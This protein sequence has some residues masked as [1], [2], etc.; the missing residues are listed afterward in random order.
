MNVKSKGPTKLLNIT[1]NQTFYEIELQYT[2]EFILAQISSLKSL[3]LDLESIEHIAT[4]SIEDKLTECIGCIQ[5]EQQKCK[6]IILNNHFGD[7][8][9]N[10][11]D[12]D[13][14]NTDKNKELK[15]NSTIFLNDLEKFESLFGPTIT[16]PNQ[17]IVEV[18]EAIGLKSAPLGGTDE[19]FC[20]VCLKC[21]NSQYRYNFNQSFLL[22]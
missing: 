4:E 15:L 14:E 1:T 2:L 11:N 9:I 6:E 8:D 19:S 3:I 13:K 5:V 7:I 16:H 18:L 20:E 17:I 22:F 12:N 21:E 10:I